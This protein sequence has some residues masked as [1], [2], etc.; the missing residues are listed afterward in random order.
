MAVLQHLDLEDSQQAAV[1]TLLETRHAA[2]DA[3]RDQAHAA[4]QAL[5]IAVTSETF[6]ETAIRAAAALV[7]A[8]DAN[9]AVADA[10]LLR[11]VRALLT[12]EQ[13]AALAAELAHPPVPFPDG[14]PR[15]GLG[16]R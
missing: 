16:R 5:R 12:D 2:M 14:P 6:D 4:H 13:K 1:A 8:L 10:A 9:R 15:R 7:A 11:D 3:T